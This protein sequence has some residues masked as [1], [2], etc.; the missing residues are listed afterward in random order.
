MASAL[1]IKAA[2]RTSDASGILML[3][4]LS[5]S[6]WAQPVRLVN[7]TRNWTSNG[8]LF[9]ALPMNF[10]LPS[11]V[12][13]QD[14]RMELQMVNVG[15]EITAE[16][17]ALPAGSVILATIQF[18]TRATPSVIDFEFVGEMQGVNTNAMSVTAQITND[19]VGRRSACTLRYD[20][21][22]APG[23]FST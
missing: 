18:A 14:A 10:K 2:Q 12:A 13:G 20:P 11:D 4:T 6:G 22:V 7:D 19:S 16:L 3:V 9:T 21:R 23:L 1:T 8:N 17:E 15:R 5:S